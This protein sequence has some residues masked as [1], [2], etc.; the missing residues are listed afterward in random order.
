MGGS[1]V[2]GWGRCEFAVPSSRFTVL[3]FLLVVDFDLGAWFLG[4]GGGGEDEAGDADEVGGAVGIAVAE[5][6]G[7]GDDGGGLVVGEL[8]GEEGI[9]FEMRWGGL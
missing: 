3:S 1:S 6:L 5:G 8:E 7:F 9:G 2:G 4:D